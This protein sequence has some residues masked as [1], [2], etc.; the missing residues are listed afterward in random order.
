MYNLP[1]TGMG[2]VVLT[3]AGLVMTGVG[4]VLRFIGRR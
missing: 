3:I 4:A 2:T 1:F